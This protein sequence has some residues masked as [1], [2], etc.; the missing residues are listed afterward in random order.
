MIELKPL[1][2][3]LSEQL[4]QTVKQMDSSQKFLSEREICR[5]YDVSRT[6]VRAALDYLEG[7]GYISRHHG[8]GT[9]TSDAWQDRPKLSMGYSFTEQMQAI[10][11]VPS[12]KILG[13]GQIVPDSFVAEE[14]HLKQGEPVWYLN[15]LRLADKRP[16]MLE[17]TY[18]PS[19]LF[20]DLSSYNL[21]EH[22]LYDLFETVYDQYI[23]FADEVFT[24]DLLSPEQASHLNATEGDAC[25]SLTRKSYNQDRVIVEYTSSV[26]R[27][28][29]F[30][31]QVR[32]YRNQ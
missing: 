15:R 7:Q 28:D 19:H 4:I 5:Q 21:E 30:Y 1:Y 3:Q 27:H 10:D 17:I 20:P 13:F 25:L 22:S 2:L 26:A 31:Y 9:F 32:H 29:C 18:L 24:A 8:K 23:L 14:L 12:S 16:M 11:K 6:T